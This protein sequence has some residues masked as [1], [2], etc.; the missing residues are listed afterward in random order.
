MSCLVTTSKGYVQQA[1]ILVPRL[2][3]FLP[4]HL[5]IPATL[6][7]T[8]CLVLCALVCQ[9]CSQ[10]APASYDLPQPC[11]VRWRMGM[12]WGTCWTK[13]PELS[14][15]HMKTTKTVKTCQLMMSSLMYLTRS[16][17]LQMLR[18]QHRSSVPAGQMSNPLMCIIY[19]LTALVSPRELLGVCMFY[20]SSIGTAVTIPADS[21]LVSRR[22]NKEH[23][24]QQKH[25]YR[26]KSTARQYHPKQKQF[27]VR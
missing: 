6:A 1:T 7:N 13:L 24:L 19:K 22:R 26:K 18:Y 25:K 5:S 11:C 3:T 27:L 9:G 15:I 16:L 23:L 4:H 2:A 20:T 17:R 14:M 12:N 10:Q 8:C 21:T